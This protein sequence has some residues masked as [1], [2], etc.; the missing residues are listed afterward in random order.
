MAPADPP[1]ARI[2]ES[3]A[4]FRALF[5]T[6]PDAVL[7][8]HDGVVALANP[9]AEKMF[10]FGPGDALY[11][12]AGVEH[13]FVEFSDDFAVWVVFYGPAGGEGRAPS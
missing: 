5:A 10:R 2:P 11:V 3:E 4:L 13:R 8:L 1:S 12:D 9:Q 7:V 6:S